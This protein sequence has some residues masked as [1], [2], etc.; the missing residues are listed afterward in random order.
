LK[1]Y[2]YVDQTLKEIQSSKNKKSLKSINFDHKKVNFMKIQKK[3]NIRDHKTDQTIISKEASVNLM[4]QQYMILFKD[5]DHT[6]SQPVNYKLDMYVT[7]EKKN[8][9]HMMIQ[10]MT[11][12][13]CS[14]D[15]VRLSNFFCFII[16]TQYH[17]YIVVRLVGINC[18]PCC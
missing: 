9:V 2:R 16:R 1:P 7:L 4:S 12:K 13:N 15:N 18:S 6:V 14:V 5:Y 3:S 10:H 11:K 17:T 8:Y